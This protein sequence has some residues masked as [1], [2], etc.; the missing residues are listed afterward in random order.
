MA[1]V[2]PK[3]LYHALLLQLALTLMEGRRH[4]RCEVCERWFDVSTGVSRRDK[5]LCSG[6]CRNRLYRQRKRE[7]T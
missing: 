2:Q 3:D 5:R 1:G 4:A 7:A 6:A